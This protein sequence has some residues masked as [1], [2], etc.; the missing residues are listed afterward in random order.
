MRT[1]R[2]ADDRGAFDFG[3]LK[4]RHTFSFG[5]YRDP[6]HTR[7]RVLRV[8]NEDW[9]QPGQG[10]GRHPHENM[11]IVTYVIS[12]AL[13]HED[14]LGNRGVI[15]A[16]EIQR[17]SAGTGIYHAESNPCTQDVCHL[18]QIWLFP[19]VKNIVP[20]WQQVA[21][22]DQASNGEGLRL[23]VSPQATQSSAMIHQDVYLWLGDLME[24]A[25]STLILAAGRGGWLQLVRGSLQLNTGELLSAGDGLA[26][27][28]Q[29]EIRLHCLQAAEFLWL[30]LP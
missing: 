9:I 28:E 8:M 19:A 30:D 23:L 16:G 10:F 18:L 4:T 12:G 29:T 11:E 5:G 22:R 6:R 3:W 20:T 1:I 17:M 26:V 27:E 7:F 13:Q 2:R 15:G 21:W 14:S 24:G 25:R